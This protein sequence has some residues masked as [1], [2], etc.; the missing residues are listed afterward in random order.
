MNPMDLL[1]QFNLKDLQAKYQEMQEQLKTLQASG[2]AGG[3]IVTIRMTGL[4]EV[5]AV[6]IA[7]EAMED[8]EMLQDLIR[9]AFNSAMSNLKEKIQEETAGSFG[10]LPFPGRFPGQV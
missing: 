1:K 4:M 9:A 5:T 3:G 7:P 8:K 2:T 10:G 6:E